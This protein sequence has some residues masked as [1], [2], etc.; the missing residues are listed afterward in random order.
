MIIL[1]KIRI[2]IVDDHTILR[3]TLVKALNLEYD[4]EV[5]GNWN[6]AEE[7]IEFFGIEPIDVFILDMKLPKM[8]GIEAA[9]KLKALNPDV[10][11]IILSAFTDEKHVFGAVEAGA[12]G[13]LP[14]EVTIEALID[15]V[16]TVYRGNAAFD[17]MLTRKIIERFSELQEKIRPAFNLTESQ[18][19]IVKYMSEGFSNKEI[20]EKL[21]ISER[22]I[23]T[24]ISEITRQ[25]GARDRTHIVSLA[26]KS[27]LLD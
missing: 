1:G 22:Q 16:R 26:Y 9:K 21:E 10:Y 3:Q 6:N 4:M 17:P 8:N 18:L 14:K 5:I 7:C 15:A 11:I 24:Y 2:G 23:R 20:S 27:G 25:T 13:Y 19:Q 12:T